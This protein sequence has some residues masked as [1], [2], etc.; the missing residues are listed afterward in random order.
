VVL[1]PD[2]AAAMFFL[3]DMERIVTLS[4]QHFGSGLRETLHKQ[5]VREV[6]GTCSG[7]HGYIVCVTNIKESGR[8]MVQVGT[9]KA[10]FHMKYTCVAFRPFKGEVVDCVVT[11]IT[12][13]G[14]FA[15]A[16]PF[17]IFVS[18]SLIPEDYEFASGDVGPC[19]MSGDQDVAIV[20]NCEVR[21]KIVGIRVDATEIFG[22]GTI[23]EDYLGLLSGPEET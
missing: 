1:G 19:F 10:T 21:V 5:L 6:E 2:S 20:R 13:L 14:F 16:G 12:K 4:P 3:L 9:G 17:A 22:I 15:D 7:K 18:S 11:Q 8:G 23:K